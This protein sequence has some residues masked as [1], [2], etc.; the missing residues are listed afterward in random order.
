MTFTQ[1]YFPARGKIPTHKSF[2][3]TD[4]TN[5]KFREHVYHPI[6]RAGATVPSNVD[7]V[8]K[9]GAV[10]EW[11]LFN[12]TIEIHTFHMHQMAF[13]TLAGPAGQP[14]MV[15][16]T[17]IPVGTVLPNPKDPNYPLMKPSVTK[18]LL[19]FR[20]VPRGTFVFHCHNL[21][22]EDRGMMGII[23]VE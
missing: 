8:V 3:L 21:F 23:R 18:V 4:T 5:S 2:F 1:Y 12:T 19:D 6:Y 9:R 10:E 13:V 22:H 7:V 16:T 17:F 15:D 11:Y 14:A 20:N